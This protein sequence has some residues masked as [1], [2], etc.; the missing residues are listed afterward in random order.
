VRCFPPAVVSSEAQPRPPRFGGTEILAS[1]ALRSRHPRPR[2]GHG[3]GRWPVPKPRPGPAHMSRPT[4]GSPSPCPAFRRRVPHLA[5]A[6]CGW[7][8]CP[9]TRCPRR[10]ALRRRATR[11]SASRRDRSRWRRLAR[12]GHA[13]GPG[14]PGPSLSRR[15]RRLQPRP[16]RGSPRSLV[17]TR[18]RHRTSRDT[19]ALPAS[20]NG[21]SAGMAHGRST[22]GDSLSVEDLARA[23]LDSDL[24]TGQIFFVN[25]KN[26]LPTRESTDQSRSW[27]S[28]AAPP[29]SRKKSSLATLACKS[30]QVITKSVHP[31]PNA[32]L[33]GILESAVCGKSARAVQVRAAVCRLVTPPVP[34]SRVGCQ[35]CWRVPR[36]WTC[37]WRSG[38]ACCGCV[39][40]AVLVGRCARQRGAVM[41]NRASAS[42]QCDSEGEGRHAV[43]R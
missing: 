25:G 14:W 19:G 5:Q 38:S 12:E 7:A 24:V 26:S 31:V 6:G 41:A 3:G 40:P 11:A 34:V 23:A 32:M 15:A 29:R 43:R 22:R 13:P 33:G 36:G 37:S 28:S 30:D 17:V 9:V 20:N 1:A 18:P 8:N 4:S 27:R 21:S 2:R 42:Q 10:Y 16:Q 39:A 35:I